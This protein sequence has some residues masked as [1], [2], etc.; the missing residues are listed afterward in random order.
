MQIS[1][2]EGSFGVLSGT[3][4]D[5]YMVPFA[6]SIDSTPFQVG[7][8]SSLGGLISPIGQIIGAREIEHR[9]RKQILLSGII[10]QASMWPIFVIIAFL[11]L[12]N[13]FL[14]N[15]AWLLILFYMLYMLCGGVMTPPWFSTMGDIVPE[16]KRGRYFAK[17][18]LITTAIALSGTLLFSVTLDWFKNQQAVILGFVIIFACGLATR[19]VS[20]SLFPR[21]YYPPFHFDPSSHITL[22]KFLGELPKNNFGKFTLFVTL[23]TFAQWVAGP[24]FSVYMLNDLNFDY[25]IYIFINLFSSI[26]ALFVFP[27]LGKFGDK[28]GNVK[29]LR[30]GACIVPFVPLMWLITNNPL[31]ILLGPQLVGGIGWTAFNLAT[32]NFIYDNIPS[33]KRGEYIALYN[34]LNGLG[35]ITG[36]L[37]GGMLISFLTITFMNEFCFLFLLSGILRLLIVIFFLPQIKE[38]RVH[39]TKPIFN[40]KNDRLYQWLYDISVRDHRGRRKIRIK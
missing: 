32:S 35:I 28:F 37:I 34:F 39:D 22:K 17:R 12:T 38:V 31:G 26:T 23:I 25:F 24:Y 20:A 33:E 29:L 8:L 15:L 16:D 10:G 13:Y 19:S 2:I 11:Y 36:G 18:N 1:I 6:L 21:H 14:I 7:I 30:F 40:L 9:P 3:L 5:N 27:A 4:S